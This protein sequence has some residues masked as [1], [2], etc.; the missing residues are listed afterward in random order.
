MKNMRNRIISGIFTIIFITFAATATFSAEAQSPDITV[1]AAES[2]AGNGKTSG[3]DDFLDMDIEQ[4]R[5]TS[6]A[7]PSFDVEV[8]SVTKSE[9]TVGRSPAAVFVITS[10]MIR[11]S[12][13][14]SI[15]ELLRMAPGMDV[16]RYNSHIWAISC[17]GF[18]GQFANKLLVL[19][20]GRTVY[21]QLYGGVYWDVQDLLL[22]DIERI[23]VIRGP[24]G[25]LWGSNAVNGV[26]N[27]IT[28]NAKD[29]QGTMVSA[30]GGNLD[31]LID[32]VRAGGNNG[33]GLHW[34]VYGKHFERGPEYLPDGAHDDW[35]MGRGG[36]R[37]DWD[38]DKH[39]TDK[40]TVLGDYYGGIEGQEFLN[41][42][43]Y[44]PYVEDLVTDVSVGGANVLA[45][46]EHRIDKE[47][48]W[49]LQTYFDRTN[50]Y[51]VD[52][53][54]QQT[55]TLDVEF[56]HRFPLAQNQSFTWGLD[57][58]Q[59][60]D[61]LPLEVFLI[62]YTPHERTTNLFSGFLQ[63]EITLVEDRLFFTIGTKLER[64]SYSGFECQPNVRLLWSIDDKHAVWSA[65]SRAVR[66]PTRFE[67]NV[68]A[69]GYGS[70]SGYPGISFLRL[71]GDPDLEA[72]V[73]MAYEIGY[74]EQTTERFSWDVTGFCNAYEN[75]IGVQSGTP[76][77]ENTYTVYPAYYVNNQRAHVYGAEFTVNWT[78]TERWRLSSSYSSCFAFSEL[79]DGTNF[80]NFLQGNTP[81]NQ[82]QLKSSWDLGRNWEF[83]MWLRY[84]DE[85]TWPQVPAYMT[86]D[87]RLGWRPRKDLEVAL[88]G[89]NLFDAHHDEFNSGG[90]PFVSSEVRRTVFAQLT[91]RR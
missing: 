33:E 19:I 20:D 4:L 42:L 41:P 27:I 10:E 9:S 62:T 83:D 59:V 74:R 60:H 13:C 8:T 86:M 57:Y 73:L 23:E 11:R 21:N 63:D 26:V 67:E 28:K 3:G 52:L 47:S 75:L 35:R 7:A 89:Q 58:R 37:L 64:N 51:E 48:D 40:L 18:N 88:V 90:G 61:Y 49:K 31:K 30:G 24:G 39:D 87:L 17:R 91:W 54:K 32:G 25:T 6:V 65:V 81:R 71:I 69:N 76:F 82:A 70:L 72:E 68:I 22:E 12:G 43:P 80:S 5:K 14:T 56:Q 29:T 34:R 66:T 15:P 85:L 44:S 1:G 84:V 36:F 16:A 78:A 46:F 50:R 45:R 53:N 79:A 38:L 55:N 2:A 77:V